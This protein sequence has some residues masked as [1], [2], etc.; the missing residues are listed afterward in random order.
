[1]PAICLQVD[2]FFLNQMN[3]KLLRKNCLTNIPKKIKRR[4]SKKNLKKKTVQKKEVLS[5]KNARSAD[6]DFLPSSE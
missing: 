1:M 2:T 3:L 4:R 6:F 5:N